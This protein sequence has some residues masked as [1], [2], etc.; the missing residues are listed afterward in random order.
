ME[1]GA[2][3]TLYGTVGV[4]HFLNAEQCSLCKYYGVWF[5]HSWNGKT[6]LTFSG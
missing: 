2:M 5:R 6:T 3:Q 1:S 4:L